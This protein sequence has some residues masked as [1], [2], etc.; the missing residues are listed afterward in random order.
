MGELIKIVDRDWGS[1]N[2][3]QRG[4]RRALFW[5]Y[6]YGL[7]LRTGNESW[8]VIPREV[9]EFNTAQDNNFRA[10]SIQRRIKR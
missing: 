9:M 3:D 10:E 4:D 7:D 1:L 5:K 8:A 2:A 6:R